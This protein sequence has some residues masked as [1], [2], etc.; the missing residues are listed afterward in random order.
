MTS[1]TAAIRY[2]RA[3]FDVSVQE[4]ADLED[5]AARIGGFDDLLRANPALAK[6]LFNPAIPAPR[7]RATVGELLKL[8]PMPPV[9]TKLLLLLAERDRLT[10]V[11][12]IVE[13]YGQRLLDHQGIVR[14]QVVTAAPLAADKSQAIEKSLGQATGRR[15][16]L[17][18]TVDPS[19]IGGIVARIGGTVYDASLTGQLAK[20]KQRLEAGD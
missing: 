19:I 8:A 18:A 7:K 16:V 14:A 6:V 4:K 15:V 20:M 12:E 17:S 10:L 13:A 9:V 3:L 5:I 11:H 2:A 1:R